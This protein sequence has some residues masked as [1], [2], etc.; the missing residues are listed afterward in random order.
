MRGGGRVA[1][2]RFGGAL[3]VNG[4]LPDGRKIRLFADFSGGF[5]TRDR[6]LVPMKPVGRASI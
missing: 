2:G 6:A 3:L 5:G 1:I 4:A